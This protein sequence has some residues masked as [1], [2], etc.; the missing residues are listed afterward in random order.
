[1]PTSHRIVTIPKLTD[2]AT[3]DSQMIALAHKSRRFRLFAL[4]E[5][6]GAFASSYE[7]EADR[8]LDQTFDRLRS[9]KAT[10]FVALA[11][12]TAMQADD[13]RET[14]VQDLMDNDWVGF[15][16]LI[17]LQNSSD[18]ISAK[19]DPIDQIAQDKSQVCDAGKPLRFHLNGMFVHPSARRAGLGKRLI[20]AA[21]EKARAESTCDERDLACTII[22]DEWND[23]A[24]SLYQRCGFQVL[25]KEIYG[26]DRVALRMELQEARMRRGG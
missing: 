7:E 2:K 11:D 15:I 13:V 16:V 17:R 25:A 1:M 14:E 23:S 26:E 12:D 18:G 10:Q 21:L 6:P 9:T 8:G 3:S 19:S 20:R 4:Q 5:S 24:R 22:V